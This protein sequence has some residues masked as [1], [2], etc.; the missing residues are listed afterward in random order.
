M[1]HELR[2]NEPNS[3]R[4][5]SEFGLTNTLSL[6]YRCFYFKLR[7]CLSVNNK[8][9]FLLCFPPF[10]SET[11]SKTVTNT[12]QVAHSGSD[13]KHLPPPPQSRTHHCFALPPKTHK[14]HSELCRETEGAWIM[15]CNPW[16]PSRA[17]R[18]Q[19]CFSL[20]THLLLSHHCSR[21]F[22]TGGFYSFISCKRVKKSKR[23]SPKI[24]PEGCQHLFF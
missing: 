11:C 12:D 14:V 15:K 20:I 4:W 21:W 17:E 9:S 8:S 19:K 22:Q 1:V 16:P 24:P 7:F 2:I 18:P 10:L 5:R 6:F 3:D 23:H 13:L